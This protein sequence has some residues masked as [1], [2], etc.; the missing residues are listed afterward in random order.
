M[1]KLTNTHVTWQDGVKYTQDQNT[2]TEGLLLDI[3]K[4]GGT[5]PFKDVVHIKQAA[6][7]LEH[8]KDSRKNDGS[9]RKDGDSP[10][11]E[12]TYVT[13]N[14]YIYIPLNTYM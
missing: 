1:A 13:S 7:H 6:K 3:P 5:E 4:Q 8:N 9:V 2:S 11:K 10:P 14:V 12:D